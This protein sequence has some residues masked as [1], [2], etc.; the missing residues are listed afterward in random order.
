LGLDLGSYL[1]ENH[2]ER[3]VSQHVRLQLVDERCLNLRLALVHGHRAD[4]AT[5]VAVSG[6]PVGHGL[7]SAA[8]HARTR[9][10]T[11]APPHF[12]QRPRFVNACFAAG[13]FW[14]FE[15]ASQVGSRVVN[16]A[17][18]ANQVASSTMRHL[19]DKAV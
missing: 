14:T 8:A 13:F 4:R 10:G 12:A 7:L 3:L 6:A 9:W 15:V 16:R 17:F 5:P 11:M 19:I 2:P 18:T 1:A